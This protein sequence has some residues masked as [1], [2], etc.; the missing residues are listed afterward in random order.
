MNQECVVN[1]EYPQP[2]VYSTQY[3]VACVSGDGL[4]AFNYF[5][6]VSETNLDYLYI[7]KTFQ[8]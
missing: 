2:R 6:E 4:Q 5:L 1:K 3:P 7:Q 8:H